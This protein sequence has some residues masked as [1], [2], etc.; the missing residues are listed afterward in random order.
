MHAE[1]NIHLV[2]RKEQKKLKTRQ[3]LLHLTW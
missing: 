1:T 2:K 3:L